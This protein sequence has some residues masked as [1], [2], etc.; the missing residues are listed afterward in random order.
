MHACVLV[1]ALV[2]AVGAVHVLVMVLVRSRVRVDS[3][4]PVFY[5]NLLQEFRARI[6]IST[7]EVQRCPR[8]TAC[9]LQ[10]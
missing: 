1:F 3:D 2:I 4:F 8:T 6:P 5:F 7:G 9:F 10:L